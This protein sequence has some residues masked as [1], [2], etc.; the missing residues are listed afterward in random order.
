MEFTMADNTPI[1]HRNRR[2]RKH[3]WAFPLG[4]AIILLA[5]VGTATLVFFAADA[6]K[7]FTG[8]GE[9]KEEY[10]KFLTQVVRNDP[11]YFDDIQDA[12]QTYLLDVAIWAFLADEGLSK[13]TYK[14]S[15]TDPIGY[16][17]PVTDIAFFY[18]KLF[19][20]EYEPQYDTVVGQGYTFIYDKA[21]ES[22]IIPLTGIDPIFIP[23]VDTIEKQGDSIILTVSCLTADKWKLNKNGEYTP[24]QANKYLK[25]TLRQPDDGTGYYVSAIQ[26]SEPPDIANPDKKA[27]TTEPTTAQQ[28]TTIL[29]TTSAVDGS[30]AETTDETGDTA[31]EGTTD[32]AVAETA[33]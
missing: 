13:K 1:E 23:R 29:E 24:P 22:Y 32:A 30:S 6:V 21:K 27:S 28:F 7:N 2:K 14:Y 31:L 18:K 19:G 12:D 10:T 9:L 16:I 15:E 20:S 26:A 11:P 4:L 17:V 25:I 3:R 8:K 33:G 5:A